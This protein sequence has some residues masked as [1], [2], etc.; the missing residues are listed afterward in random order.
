M[1]IDNF[2]EFPIIL[3]QWTEKLESKTYMNFSTRNEAIEYLFK[4]YEDFVTQQSIKRKVKLLEMVDMLSF[5]YSFY[6]FAYLELDA[7]KP[8]YLA[9][10]KDNFSEIL[11]FYFKNE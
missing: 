9:Y 3:I 8:I 1:N 7:K 10:G 5:I 6:D 4:I 2:S 11:K